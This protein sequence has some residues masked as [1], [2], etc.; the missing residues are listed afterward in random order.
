VRVRTS[1]RDGVV[2]LH[3]EGTDALD[4]HC[5]AEF[6]QAAVRELPHG[7]DL[8]V[9][10]TE[11]DFV[12]SAGVGA[13]VGL[14]KEARARGSRVRFAGARAGVVSVLEIIRLDRIFDLSDDVESATRELCEQRRTEVS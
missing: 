3:L 6:E 12:D 14:Y 2:V 4:T 7:G 1:E 11:V 5:A 13:C 8:V 9:D 10:M